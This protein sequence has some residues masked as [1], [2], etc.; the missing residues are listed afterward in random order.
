MSM[1]GSFIHSHPKLATA[2]LS[3]TRCMNKQTVVHLHQLLKKRNTMD[4]SQSLSERSQT[5][6]LPC[7]QPHLVHS[8]EGKAMGRNRPVVPGMGSGSEG[9]EGTLT[10]KE[11]HK[12]ECGVLCV[13]A[14]SLQSYPT[15]CDPTDW[16]PPDFSVHEILQARIL[17]QVAPP[18]R[19]FLTQGLNPRF[20]SC[21]HWQ[22]GSLPLAPPGKPN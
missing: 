10:M 20:L 14:K 13:C 2:Q 11:Q 21:L 18:P 15:P 16:S 6:K 19:I 4:K 17:E 22:V 5:P 1:Y 8:G 9:K 3:F 12:G 7:E